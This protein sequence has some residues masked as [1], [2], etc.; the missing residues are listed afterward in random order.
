[1]KITKEDQLL[2]E[3]DPLLEIRRNKT[4]ERRSQEKGE[5]VGNMILQ[6]E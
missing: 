5:I 3:N 2:Q 6:K 1:M 4:N